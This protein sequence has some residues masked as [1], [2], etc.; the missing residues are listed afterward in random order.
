MG[1]WPARAFAVLI[2]FLDAGR[3]LDAVV[4]VEL[5]LVNLLIGVLIP[6]SFVVTLAC[7]HEAIP[8]ARRLW[9]RLGLVSA[10]MWATV[11]MSAYLRQLTVVRLAEEQSHLGEVSLIGFGELDR[12]SAGWS[13]NVSGWGVFLTL[14]LFFVSPAVVGNGRARLGRWA[15]RLSGV[16]MRLLAVGFAA[17]SEPVQLLGAGFGWFLGLPVSGLVLASILSSARTGTP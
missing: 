5:D 11:S 13:L 12:T 6:L 15:L 2:W 17:G 9:T 3:F 8:P 4:G 16:S 14:A 7:L 1:P 10:G